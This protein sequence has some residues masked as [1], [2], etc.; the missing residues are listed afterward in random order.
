MEL[1]FVQEPF[2]KL[3]Q[4]FRNLSGNSQESS[5]SR[6]DA[7]GPSYGSKRRT[8]R[9]GD[10]PKTSRIVQSMGVKCPQVPA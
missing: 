10:P 8:C 1:E 6:S 4:T 5:K 3:P 7:L 9:R 2:W